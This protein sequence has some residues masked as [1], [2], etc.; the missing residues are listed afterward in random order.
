MWEKKD[1]FLIRHPLTKK[2]NV[3]RMKEEGALAQ[4]G[5][6]RAGSAKVTGSSPVCSIEKTLAMQGFFRFTLPLIL[7][8]ERCGIHVP[9]HAYVP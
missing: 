5:E 7:P 2:Q 3:F 9:S 6:H 4:L 1:R 8:P